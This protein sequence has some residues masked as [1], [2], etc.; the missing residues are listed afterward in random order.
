VEETEGNENCNRK[1][2][3]LLQRRK[4]GMGLEEYKK[5]CTVVNSK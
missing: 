4:W 2:I 1:E 3:V 5:T